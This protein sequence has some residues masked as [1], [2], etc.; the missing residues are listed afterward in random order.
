MFSQ[1]GLS[2]FRLLQFLLLTNPILRILVSLLGLFVSNTCSP[3]KTTTK[4]HPFHVKSNW[5][6]PIQC[7][8]TLE[9]Y[10]EDTKL[11]IAL[12]V[13]YPQPDNISQGERATINALKKND[14]LNLKKVD[15]G[16]NTVILNTTQ[17][18]EEGLQQLSDDKFY[19]FFLRLMC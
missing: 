7:S 10:L 17:K 18:I 14:E 9:Q 4:P 12:M 16:T 8:A 19:N 3:T 2:S 5:Q 1:G 6:P 15:K 13:F 11:E